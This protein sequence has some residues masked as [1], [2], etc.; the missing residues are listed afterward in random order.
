[1]PFVLRA[2]SLEPAA[3]YHHVVAAKVYLRA[4][5]LDEAQREVRK[6]QSLPDVDRVQGLVDTLIA[7]IARARGSRCP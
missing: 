7:D 6:A 5:R 3:A 1:V 2:V 4:N